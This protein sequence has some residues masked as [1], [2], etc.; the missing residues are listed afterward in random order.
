MY[1]SEN[2]GGGFR[3]S[4]EREHFDPEDPEDQE[5]QRAEGLNTRQSGEEELWG[6]LHPLYCKT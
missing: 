4:A 5:L 6:F 1:S 3:G 2:R